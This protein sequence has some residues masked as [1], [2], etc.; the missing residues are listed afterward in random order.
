VL[1]LLPNLIL[2]PLFSELIED[3][4][5]SRHTLVSDKLKVV[6]LANVQEVTKQQ[7]VVKK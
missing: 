1:S 4:G 5:G 7:D 3:K 2:I 6:L